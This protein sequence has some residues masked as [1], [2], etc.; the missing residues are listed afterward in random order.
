M[1]RNSNSFGNRT[2]TKFTAALTLLTLLPGELAAQGPQ[3][4]PVENASH[5]PVWLWFVGA[6][7]LGLALAYG[8]MRNRQRTRTDKAVTEQATRDRYAREN[9]NS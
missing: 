7:L 4:Q 6:G 9:R 1:L 5:L 3:G 2:A 8:I